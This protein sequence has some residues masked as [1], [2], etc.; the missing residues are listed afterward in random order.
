MAAAAA[1]QQG[2][3]DFSGFCNELNAR[4]NEVADRIESEAERAELR[5]FIGDCVGELKLILAGVSLVHECTPRTLDKILAAGERLS[6]PLVAAVLRQRGV[7]AEPCDARNLIVTDR[8]F[9]NAT[10]KTEPSYQ[11]IRE[12]FEQHSAVQVV[13]GFLSAT[14]EGE[15]TTLGRGASDYTASLLGAGLKADRIEI[16]TDVDG[17]QSADPRRVPGAFSLPRLSYDELLEL[18]HF[19]AKVVAPPTVHPARGASIPLVIKNT[20]N[21]S[22]PGTLVL[23]ETGPS[24]HPIRGISSISK[25]ALLR[26]EGDGMI[27][28]PGTAGR[29]FHA[30]AQEGV[31]VILISQASSQHSICVAID[32]SHVAQARE[33]IHREFERERYAHLIDD[34]VV[35][36]DFSVVAVVGAEMSHRPG[37]SGRLFGALGEAGINVGAI[38]QGSSELNISCAVPAREETRALQILHDA[39]F[40]TP[41]LHIFLLGIGGVGSEL[42]SQLRQAPASGSLCL[43]GVA[44]SRH[45]SLDRHRI[46]PST[47]YPALLEAADCPSHDREELEA[48][49]LATPG[50]RVLVDCTASDGMGSLYADL[51]N[52]GVSVVTA[53]KKPLADRQAVWDQIV[54]AQSPSARLYFEATV[55]AGLPSS[56]PSKI[57]SQPATR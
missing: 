52:A 37:I 3:A 13:T 16:W 39:F 45:M 25:V 11:R 29:L 18:S 46:D 34:L 23:E 38:A 40:V 51:L 57:S 56:A 47:W 48:Y 22:F 6:S 17:V 42:L 10:V 30:L 55:G 33:C 4:H 49:I 26:L 36:D 14:P 32:P 44:N 1:S 54:E 43:S 19:G 24:E 8:A 5:Q 12:H 50:A 21:P 41:R 53:N 35:D 2:D 27:G 20:L 28:L 31:T 15:T 9:G 7:D